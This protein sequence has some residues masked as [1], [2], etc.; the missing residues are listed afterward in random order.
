M[1]TLHTVVDVVLVK[2]KSQLMPSTFEV[3]KNYLLHL[4]ELGEELNI[5]EPCQEL[6]DAF[7]SRASTPDLHFQLCHAVRL[8]DAEAGTKAFAPNGWLY[9]EPPLPSVEES[10]ALFQNITFPVEDGMIDTGH[11]II[12]AEKEMEYLQ[13]TLSTSGQYMKAWRELYTSLYLIGD[14]TFTRKAV[15]AFVDDAAEQ[16]QAGK[17]RTWKWKIRRRS[18]GI[19][20]EV[21]ST[22]RFEWKQIRSDHPRCSDDQLDGLRIQYIMFL[23]TRNLEKNTIDLHDYAFRCIIEETGVMSLV[24]LKNLKPANIQKMLTALSKRLCVN[25]CGTIYPVIR[26]ILTYLYVGGFIENDFSGMVLTP[27]YQRMH[28]RPYLSE[29]DEAKLFDALAESP[30]RTRAMI[31]LAIRLGLRDID[32]CNLQFN[33]ID[34]HNDQIV[35]EQEKTG[36]NISLPLLEDV[37]NS[38][39]DYLVNERPSGAKNYPYVFVHSQAPYRKLS[40]MY[41]VCSK[42][43]SK[44][45]VET[46]NKDSRG[47]H[48]CRYTLT[49]NLL[50][51]KVPHQVITDTLGHVSKES[52]KPYLSMEEEMLRE[53]PLDFSLIG[54]KYWE[55]GDVNA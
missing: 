20:L 27:R 51:A 3:R 4:A 43:F 34:W 45:G 55:E 14:T 47:V 23:R 42:L 30:L 44:A 19:L 32:I 13:L 54:Q 2:Q 8:V 33:Q 36:E 53:C 50:K 21:A 39:M 15:S 11:L 7:V 38:I 1:D 22:G 26:Q 49:H 5:S 17:I 24:E 9:N 16:L 48:V 25:S 37:G 29:T 28:L 31:R 46:I 18:A 40:S 35:L 6:F 12:R 10:D 41:M 52:D